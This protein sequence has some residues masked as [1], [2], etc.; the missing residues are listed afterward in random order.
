MKPAATPMNFW[1]MAREYLLAAQILIEADRRAVLGFASHPTLLLL[2]HGIEL[3]LK[4]YLLSHG[5]N[6]KELKKIR[7]DLVKA[8]EE[9]ENRG[10]RQ[11]GRRDRQVV[12]WINEYYSKKEFEYVVE[13]GGRSLPH[14][15]ILDQVLVKLVNRLRTSCMTATI[16]A[17][18]AP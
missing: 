10:L 16:I 3:A 4:A 6:A 15:R 1:S 7:H 2:S 12:R 13:Q 11:L 8:L 18:A 5:L 17:P 14:V 9:A